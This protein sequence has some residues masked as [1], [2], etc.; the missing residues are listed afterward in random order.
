M[1]KTSLLLSLLLIGSLTV[2]ATTAIAA[3]ALT[4]LDVSSGNRRA[5]ISSLYD[6]SKAGYRGNGVLPGNNE[7]NP[8]ATCQITAAELA[9]Q[10]GV[11]PDDAADDTAGLQAAIDAIRT[12]CSPSASYTKLST[13]TLPAGRLKVSKELHADADYLIIRGAG[14]TAT[15]IV[16]TPDATTRYDS[17][18]PDGSDWDEDGMTSGQGKGG[19]L[20]P[21]RGLFRVQSRG[22]HSSYASDYAAAPENRKDIF[23][24]TVNVHWKTGV[25]VS[26]A[27]KSGDRTVKVTSSSAIK[28]GMLVN[29]RAA[30]S[31]KFYEQQFA[32]GTPYPM[33]NMHMR[34]QIFTVTSVSGTTVTLDKPLE[35][36]VP[37]NS[38]SD[39]SPAIGGTT[40]DSKVSP[41]VD[42]VLGVG[43]EN[44]G[45]TQAMP[46]L[47]P[48]EATNNYGNMA[49]AD[50][51]H[52]IVFKWAANSWVKGI[53][54]EMTGSHPIVTEEAKNLQIVDN[55]LDGSWNKGKGGNGYF[56][57]SRVWDSLYAG[58]TSRNLRHFTF[59]WS[60]S[61]NV[62]VGNDFD[63][64]LNLH[65]GWERNNLF[66][67]NSVKV[68]YAH[69]SGNCRANCGEEGGGGPDDSNWFP[70]WWG[71]GKKAVKWS[72]ATGPR[73]VFFNNGMTKQ[74][75]TGG[76]YDPFYS[77]KGRVYQFGWNGSAYKH[78]DIG[79]TAITDWA[80]NEQ[81]DYTGGHGVDAS[82]TDTAKSLFLKN[83]PATFAAGSTEDDFG[84]RATIPVSTADQLRTALAGAKPGDTISLAPGTYRGAFV[85]QK[86]GT[87]SNPITLSG[88]S[89]AVLVNDGPSG[90]APSCPAPTAGWDSG[91]G[92]WLYNA[93]YWNI[94]GITVAE[95]K[96]GIILD[97]SHHVTIDGVTVRRTDEE[98]VHFR[99]SSADGV[100]RNS[101]ITDAGVVTKDYGE[102][103][104]I[105]SANSNWKCHG[106][107]GGVDRSDRVQVIGNRIG[108]GVS[109]EHIDVKEGTQ[110]GLISGNTFNGTG[111]SG[112]NSADSWV[113]VKGFGYRIE[114]NTG[115]FTSPG[116]FK[117]GYETHNP[118]T[119]PSFGNGC[120]NVWR[121]NRSDLGNVGE[122][123]VYVSST[124]KCKANPNVVHASNTVSR[125]KKGVS[126][127]PV[128]P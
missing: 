26:A 107:T 73:N 59:Q 48:A 33:L 108:P 122:Y 29:V 30:N 83:I 120:G 104:Y 41:L 50:E 37:V 23:E 123:A 127:I 67:N 10:F 6:W 86:A 78:L 8:S 49:P 91:Y 12:Q 87:S 125:A 79:G 3:P 56:R 99:R 85:S 92:L 97:N 51:M 42:P 75:S 44:F 88:P 101:T 114:N 72:G 34:Q 80:K 77:E 70:I 36:D 71:A 69:R 11:R 19:W 47:D 100:I 98:G 32:T 9:S 21:G 4:G 84:A 82:K 119:T 38:T 39:G 117:N 52:G 124:S 60:A 126:N 61:G 24:G 116:T 66:E 64:D 22:V 25:K 46:N 16:Y 53:R 65:G 74:L 58:N 35:F 13:I 20:W 128:T 2:P 76:S 121:N 27:A 93:P 31:V 43:F 40:Y 54:A 118:S 14:A 103:V 102:G 113:D 89:S 18:T 45:F 112:A 5:P 105:G 90:T 7:I 55:H 115:T 17:L 68:S 15:K 81:R 109:A 96:K 63:S 110:G 106:N 94:K 62:V 1:P 57:G 28:A 111:I 95:S